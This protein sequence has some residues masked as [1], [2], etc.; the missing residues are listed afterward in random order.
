[1]TQSILEPANLL[2]LRRKG[3]PKPLPPLEPIGTNGN[4]SRASVE[5]HLAGSRSQHFLVS[6]RLF[7]KSKKSHAKIVHLQ[8]KVPSPFLNAAL[9]YTKALHLFRKHG[10]SKPSEKAL[11]DAFRANINVPIYLSDIVEMPD[12]PPAY[13]G[14]G[15]DNEA[16]AYVM[17]QGYLW[18][19]TEGASEWMAEKLAADLQKEIDDRELVEEVIKALKGEYDD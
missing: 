5:E 17:D 6:K 9:L 1:M 8:P 18:W 4:S 19:D 2:K 3:P 11:K 15:D 12:D 14:F 10:P 7:L 13:I 16:I